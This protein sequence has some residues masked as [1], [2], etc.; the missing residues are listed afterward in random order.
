MMIVAN[1]WLYIAKRYVPQALKLSRNLMG[2]KKEEINQLNRKILRKSPR[3]LLV[4]TRLKTRLYGSNY[5]FTVV[6]FSTVHK[7]KQEINSRSRSER[8]KKLKEL[9]EPA[10][11]ALRNV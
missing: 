10:G 8:K 7:A 9:N 2:R 5:L 6:H 1:L 4:V 11:I 3:I